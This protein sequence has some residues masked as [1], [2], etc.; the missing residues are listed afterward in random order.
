MNT[1]AEKIQLTKWILDTDNPR[2]LETIKNI[3]IKERNMDFWES[4]TG[5]QKKD[6]ELG[7]AEISKGEKIEYN[8]FMG[9]FR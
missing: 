8:T 7:I 2:I 5:E 4:L 1:Q 3:F 9:K 6:I